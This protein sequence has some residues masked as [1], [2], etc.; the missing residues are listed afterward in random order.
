[1]V[2]LYYHLFTVLKGLYLR[3]K[4]KYSALLS[5]SWRKAEKLLKNLPKVNCFQSQQADNTDNVENTA[6]KM[7]FCSVYTPALLF[8][9]AYNL[10]TL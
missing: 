5:I 6:K 4:N 1:M 10:F 8:L 9:V 3:A 7:A 2:S